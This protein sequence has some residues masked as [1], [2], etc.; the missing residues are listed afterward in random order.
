[1]I[2][3]L[4]GWESKGFRCPDVSV[5]MKIG[6]EIAHVALLQM[7]NGTGKTT[8]LNL[9]R[10]S[11]NGE[12]VK[13][14][15]EQILRFRKPLA[16]NEFGVFRVNLLVDGKHLTFELKLDFEQCI[17]SYRTTA[18]GSGGITNGWNPPASVHRFFAENF[19]RLFIFDGEFAE[20]LLDSRYSEAE[21]AI[22][23]LCQIY[24]LDEILNEAEEVWKNHAKNSSVKTNQGLVRNQNFLKKIETQISKVNVAKA[25]YTSKIQNLKG[26][27]TSLQEKFNKLSTDQD[28]LRVAYES[29]LDNHSVIT[30]DLKQKIFEVINLVR[31]PYVLTSNFSASLINL[32]DNLD[33]L[34]L[35]ST[36]SQ[37]FFVELLQEDECICGR[38]LNNQTR[39]IISEKSQGYLAEETS[40]FLNSLKQ[41]IDTFVIN[42]ESH[43]HEDLSVLLS[44]LSN[45][46]QK[47]NQAETILRATREALVDAGGE[48]LQKIEE[49]LSKN[50]QE[51]DNAEGFLNEINRNPNDKSLGGQNIPD[52]ENT[53]C[54]KSLEK[55]R[56]E[57]QLKISE[58]TGTLELRK[59][60]NILKAIISKSITIARN[61]IRDSLLIQ[62]NERLKSILVR[63]PLQ[64]ESIDSCLKL[65]HQD[66]ASVGQTLAVGYTF[67][68]SLLHKGQNQFPLV[69][70]SPANS[71]SIEVRREIGKL[72]PELCLQFVGFTISS[73]RDGFVTSLDNLSTGKIKYMTLF[74]KNDGTFSLLK[75]LNNFEFE[76]N[77]TGVIVHGK[78]YFNSFD[79]E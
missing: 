5:D 10:A 28:Q 32:K 20:K 37:Q 3:E 41:D 17:A 7:P 47:K 49:A 24:L 39:Q 13:W 59:K 65:R 27:I 79:K 23:S 70:D 36:T 60:T 75:N 1:M 35:P 38:P 68:T 19:V 50:R 63:N 6:S 31:K 56:K 67:L 42:N 58:I 34:K 71:L 9:L 2:I 72:I 11:M 14:S 55:Q 33:K 77:D 40:G 69:V 46:S 64:I 53:L 48:E 25:A 44:E 30:N 22:D 12:A 4:L 76:E 73:E 54:L 16:T 15:S 45:L 57:C 62:C 26:E 52:D 74:G 43:K 18:P 51:L 61:K 21:K 29:A 66:G 78:D 8:T